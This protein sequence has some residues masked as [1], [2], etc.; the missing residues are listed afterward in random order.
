MNIIDTMQAW[1]I[2]DGDQIVV[3]NDHI[4]VKTFREDDSDNDAVIVTGYSHDSG[5]SVEYTL[6]FDYDVDVWGIVG[7]Y[8][9][10]EDW[11]E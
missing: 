3:D 4:E 2:S 1:Q 11:N 8:D 10:V 5:D 7:T 6:P 9:E